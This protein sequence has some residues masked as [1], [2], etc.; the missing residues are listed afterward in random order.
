[1]RAMY[2]NR[3]HIPDFER[4]RRSDRKICYDNALHFRV[5]RL[6]C[7]FN[8]SKDLYADLRIALFKIVAPLVLSD[9]ISQLALVSGYGRVPTAR[10][11]ICRFL[12]R[13]LTQITYYC[14][15]FSNNSQTC[16]NRVMAVYT[17]SQSWMVGPA[18]TPLPGAHAPLTSEHSKQNPPPYMPNHRGQLQEELQGPFALGSVGPRQWAQTSSR[19]DDAITPPGLCASTARTKECL[20][21]RPRPPHWHWLMPRN[22]TVCG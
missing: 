10:H 14:H 1:M 21:R 15:P 8:L 22:P 19:P 2:L 18:D 13:A 11:A 9:E 7:L 16:H 4:V 6:S 12:R 3:N 20:T 17:Y 5:C